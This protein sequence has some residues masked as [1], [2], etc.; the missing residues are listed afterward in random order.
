MYTS[1]CNNIFNKLNATSMFKEYTEHVKCFPE[2]SK[3]KPERDK[4]F[5]FKL[6]A[7]LS[8]LVHYFASH[9]LLCFFYV[10]SYFM[11]LSIASALL[12]Q[13]VISISVKY[14]TEYS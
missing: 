6:Q 5:L 4:E 12:S 10:P 13:L 7:R 11:Y 3:S 14:A 9:I 2:N 1:A 8:R